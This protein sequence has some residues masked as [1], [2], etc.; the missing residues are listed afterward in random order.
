M[1]KPGVTDVGLSTNPIETDV[2]ESLP[3]L[4]SSSTSRTISLDIGAVLTFADS[5]RLLASVLKSNRSLKRLY[6]SVNSDNWIATEMT[7]AMRDVNCT[8][9]DNIK[10]LS[11]TRG[12]GSLVY[13]C[14]AEIDVY[15]VL[16]CRGCMRR[17][18]VRPQK[19]PFLLKEADRAEGGNVGRYLHPLSRENPAKWAAYLSRGDA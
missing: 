11:S 12:E 6:V 19:I 16:S 13:A 5:D 9:D 15:T 10:D 14:Q 1:A 7:R 17:L 8:L 2:L 4:L 3:R 18:A